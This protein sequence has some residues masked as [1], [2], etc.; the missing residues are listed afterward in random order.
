MRCLR[1]CDVCGRRVLWQMQPD[2]TYIGGGVCFNACVHGSHA[3]SAGAWAAARGR[4]VRGGG[5]REEEYLRGWHRRRGGHV[6]GYGRGAHRLRGRSSGERARE[7][8]QRGVAPPPPS[9]L[10][11]RRRSMY[12]A[13]RQRWFLGI[14]GCL[15]L[16][17]AT[18]THPLCVWGDTGSMFV[19]GVVAVKGRM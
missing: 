4:R 12:G 13:P 7:L 6:R 17:L 2:Q 19:G 11:A 3:C 9:P 1:A 18:P 10:C 5:A 16:R 14:L 8:L 15:G